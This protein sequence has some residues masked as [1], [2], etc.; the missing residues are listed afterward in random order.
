M[1]ANPEPIVTA[2]APIGAVVAMLRVTNIERS[3]PFY[4]LLGFRV[5]NYVP[6]EAP[7][8]A[9]WHWVWLY[10]PNA[11][12]W[13][14]GAN[15]MLVRGCDVDANAQGILFYLYA[16]DLVSLREQLLAAGVKCGEISYPEYLPKGEFE[17]FDP[18]GYR[19][20]IAQSYEHSP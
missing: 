14:T 10:Q 8:P 6:R 17:T 2:A 15:L 5:G 1:A 16:A 3:L 13:K 4:S 7:A 11:A 20:M 12:N 9:D 19:L 18:E